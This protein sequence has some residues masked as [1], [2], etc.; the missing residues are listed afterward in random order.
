M[1]LTGQPP[2]DLAGRGVVVRRQWDECTRGDRAGT[3]SDGRCGNGAAARPRSRGVDAGG[4][5]QDR[6]AGGCDGIGAGRLAGRPRR[7]GAAGRCRAHPQPSPGPSDQVR[8]GSRCRS[9]PSG[10]RVTRA[11]RGSI[12]PGVVAPRE[13][14]IGGGTVFVYS[15]RGSQWA[16]MG[17]QLLADE[18]AFAAAI[19]E[20]E[21]EFVAQGGFRCAT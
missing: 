4:V 7:G 1:V 18:P 20:L 9:A 21:P 16:G 2:V 3:R 10:D 8:H 5:R 14:S 6:T 11:G 19:A 15:G 17:R 13:G 12:R